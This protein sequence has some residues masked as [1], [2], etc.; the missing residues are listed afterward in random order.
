MDFRDKLTMFGNGLPAHKVNE[1]AMKLT[2]KLSADELGDEEFEEGE[3]PHD[4]EFTLRFTWEVCGSCSGRGS[5]VN[6]SIDAHGITESER[7]DWDHD[8]E[9]RYFSGA[10]DITCEECKGRRVS[11]QVVADNS[12]GHRL[13]CKAIEN[14][15]EYA[16]E[17]AHEI[18]YGY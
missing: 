10:Y 7:A 15:A 4:K 16:R 5:Y 8:E 13:W 12:E 6:P 2:F 17:R 1:Q 9:E 11:P 3:E 14:H 18:R